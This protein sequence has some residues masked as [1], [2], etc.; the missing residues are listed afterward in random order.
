MKQ[1]T[2]FVCLFF[3][4]LFSYKELTDILLWIS[5]VFSIPHYVFDW[6]GKATNAQYFANF[7]TE[8]LQK[9]RSIRPQMFFKIG[10]FQK[11]CNISRKHLRWSL[12]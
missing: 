9:Y 11:F 8:A 3:D 2:V 7:M 6:E 4:S 12:L 10:V 5:F 1:L